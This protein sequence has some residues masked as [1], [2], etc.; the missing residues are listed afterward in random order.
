VI[1][2]G[3]GIPIP[4]IPP[5]IPT[6]PPRGPT[7]PLSK[8]PYNKHL[9][10]HS[11]QSVTGARNRLFSP[12]QYAFQQPAPKGIG[13]AAPS[14]SYD[15]RGTPH[16]FTNNISGSRNRMS[17]GPIITPVP[18]TI[19]HKRSFKS[20]GHARSATIPVTLG[21]PGSLDVQT[22]ILM[23]QKG[24]EALPAEG[25]PYF[26]LYLGLLLRYVAF[27]LCLT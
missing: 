25:K 18:P 17:E 15:T 5:I 26:C 6:V 16:F 4:P 21:A 3:H 8:R 9:R 22:A 13:Y 23:A 7:P 1:M 12:S 24:R 10:S 14:T 27:I 19:R 11:S 20:N 2:G